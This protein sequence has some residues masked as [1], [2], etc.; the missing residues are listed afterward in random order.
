MGC[1]WCASD[2]GGGRGGVLMGREQRGKGVGRGWDS[3]G[4]AEPREEEL[5]AA[6]QR[7]LGRSEDSHTQR[8]GWRG[9]SPGDGAWGSG[10]PRGGCRADRRGDG[11][12]RLVEGAWGWRGTQLLDAQ[13]D[14]AG[15]GSACQAAQLRGPP[16]QPGPRSLSC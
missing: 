12:G 2:K 15:L 9:E 7:R 8:S 1:H 14:R 4:R 5:P 10:D 6:G 16:Q 11:P 3:S 13:G